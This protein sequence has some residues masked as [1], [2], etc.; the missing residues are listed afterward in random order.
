[1]TVSQLLVWTAL[2]TGIKNGEL[3]LS[4]FLAPQLNA[5]APPT[6]LPTPYCTACTADSSENTMPVKS[7]VKMTIAHDW[8]PRR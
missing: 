5:T 2:P 3:T 6:K 7:D 4:V 1:M 8:T